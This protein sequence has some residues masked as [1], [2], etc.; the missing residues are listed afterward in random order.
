MITM[1]KKKQ[2]S[3]KHSAPR[4]AVQFPAAWIEAA[5]QEASTRPAPVMWYIVELIKKDLEAKGKR[6]PPTPWPPAGTAPK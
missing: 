6:T 1:S 4:R 3:G 2:N 5:E